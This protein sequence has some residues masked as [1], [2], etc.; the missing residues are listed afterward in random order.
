[1][2]SGRCTA[3]TDGL[4]RDAEMAQS[5]HEYVLFFYGLDTT[6]CC[7]FGHF[8]ERHTQWIPKLLKST[9]RC[10]AVGR[11]EPG[12]V[13]RRHRGRMEA[14]ALGLR[15]SSERNTRRYLASYPAWCRI[16]KSA[17]DRRNYGEYIEQTIGSEVK[18]PAP[19]P[20]GS[21]QS[22]LPGGTFPHP[23]G[24]R[25]RW[26]FFFFFFGGMLGMTVITPAT[27]SS[28]KFACLLV[29]SRLTGCKFC[30]CL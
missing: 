15:P 19:T 23:P 24:S 7:F 3:G 12:A 25:A 16:S 18:H 17:P 14:V 20:V 11:E 30:Q 26:R 29:S 28:A 2:R 9:R 8:P 6:S 4:P 27:P 13:A 21:G 10:G 22:A 1:M 5:A